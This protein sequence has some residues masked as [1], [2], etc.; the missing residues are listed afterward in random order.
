MKVYYSEFELG[1]EQHLVKVAFLLAHLDTMHIVAQT[2]L[3]LLT[4][5]ATLFPHSSKATASHL[6]PLLMF[7]TTN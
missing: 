1:L 7:G 2:H 4:H 6:I 5:T 3:V